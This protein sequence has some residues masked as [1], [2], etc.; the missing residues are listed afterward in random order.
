MVRRN[1][2][3]PSATVHRRDF[4]RLTGLA[5]GGAVLASCSAKGDPATS[6]V[7]ATPTQPPTPTVR[8]TVAERNYSY[9]TV[10]YP[11]SVKTTLYGINNKGNTAG[12]FSDG[13]GTH[14]FLRSADGAI[15][16][17][18]DHPEAGTT[19][20]LF[21]VNGAGDAVG[22]YHAKSDKGG[23]PGTTSLPPTGVS[24]FV[25]SAAAQRFEPIAPPEDGTG[26][27]VAFGVNDSG[28]VSGWYFARDP[29]GQSE[30]VAKGFVWSGKERRH[31]D[32]FRHPDDTGGGTFATGVNGAGLVVGQLIGPDKSTR[33][34]I[35]DST[36]RTFVASSFGYPNLRENEGGTGAMAISDSGVVAGFYLDTKGTH[37]YLRTDQSTFVALRYPPATAGMSACGVNESGVVVGDF[38]DSSGANLGYLATPA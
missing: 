11:K 26:T 8:A 33:V 2:I 13:R 28:L 9:V 7:P 29:S 36:R 30:A 6:S 34:F 4:L 38:N 17:A 18:L 10:Q 21:G 25:Y 16:A 12:Y 27:V 15:S 24:A 14:G 1:H 23:Y 22:Y 35:R 20:A 31:V 32:T 37:A 3:H 5:F 19:T